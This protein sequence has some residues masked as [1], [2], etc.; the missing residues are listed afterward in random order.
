MIPNYVDEVDEDYK[1]T[2]NEL[3]SLGRSAQN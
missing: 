2:G 3:N 1:T